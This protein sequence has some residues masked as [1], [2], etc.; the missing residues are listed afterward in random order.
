LA[1]QPPEMP[2]PITIASKDVVSALTRE[3]IC[4]V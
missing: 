2:E 1:A 3:N 4:P